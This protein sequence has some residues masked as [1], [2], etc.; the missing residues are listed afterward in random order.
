MRVFTG[1]AASALIVIALQWP[2][3]EKPPA[4]L[5]VIAPAANVV[6]TTPG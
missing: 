5:P 4:P 1:A 3:R 2:R 6:D